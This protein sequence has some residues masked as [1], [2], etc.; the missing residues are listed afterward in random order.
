MRSLWPLR[1]AVGGE[2]SENFNKLEEIW[3]EYQVYEKVEESRE[4]EE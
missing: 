2:V 4:D 3:E 1:S